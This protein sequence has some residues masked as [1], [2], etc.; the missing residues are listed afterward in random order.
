MKAKITVNREKVQGEVSPLLFGHFMEHAFGNIYGGVYDPG[1]PLSDEDGFRTDVLELLKEEG[2]HT[3]EPV[4]DAYAVIPDAA[5]L[6]QAMHCL[7]Q[8]RAL[9]SAGMRLRS[10]S[11]ASS[12]MRA[13]RPFCADTG[14]T[15]AR[16]TSWEVCPP[17]ALRAAS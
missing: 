7:Q 11:A 5:V 2:V 16:S 13:T 9:R 17:R 3:L 1:H 6:P 10:S 4:P 15:A 8:L 12:V 14:N